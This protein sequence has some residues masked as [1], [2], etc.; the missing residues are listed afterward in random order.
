MF[1]K[2]RTPYS[3]ETRKGFPPRVAD[4]RRVRVS[5]ASTVFIMQPDSNTEVSPK[6]H[7]AGRL[8]TPTELNALK[9]ATA[10]HVSAMTG[11]RVDQT[12]VIQD[13]AMSSKEIGYMEK[14]QTCVIGLQT[15]TSVGRAHLVRVD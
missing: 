9:T 11:P 10:L 4:L 6:S 7:G 13:S 12:L 14:F 8:A 15:H 1:Q 3:I 5:A 2:T